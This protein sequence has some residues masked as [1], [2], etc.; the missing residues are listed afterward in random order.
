MGHPEQH[1]KREESVHTPL[2]PKRHREWEDEARGS[3]SAPNDEKR[4]RLEEHLPPRLPSAHERPPS[5]PNHAHMDE[6][7][8]AEEHRRIND[9]YHPSEAAHHP[10]T[11]GPVPPPQ[12]STPQSE[13][14]PHS[15]TPQ[16][17]PRPKDSPPHEPPARKMEVDENYDDDGEDEKRGPPSATPTKR[18]SPRTERAPTSDSKPEPTKVEA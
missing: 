12:I 8:R 9:G 3:Q 6:I 18:E 15:F 17:A 14:P 13:A 4:P 11:L 16:N 2:P 1:H 7:R 5:Q 10:P